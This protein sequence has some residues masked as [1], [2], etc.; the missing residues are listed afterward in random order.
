[1]KHTD[2][3]RLFSERNFQPLA[4]WDHVIVPYLVARPVLIGAGAITASG[5]VL[6]SRAAAVTHVFHHSADPQRPIVHLRR[7]DLEDEYLRIQITCGDG[8][9]FL[10]TTRRKLSVTSNI[11]L[12]AVDGAFRGLDL[13]L[14][15][16]IAAMHAVA[17]D[18]FA[19]VQLRDGKNIDAPSILEQILA[20]LK[21]SFPHP[22]GDYDPDS[23]A[24][25][26]AFERWRRTS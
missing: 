12:A 20:T 10:G 13:S 9:T 5:F 18:P 24:L 3:F 14:R 6:S 21:G 23:A 16:P 17:R 11:L 2:Y 15:N 7:P 8:N 19:R 25:Q 4:V 26:D 22:F 1:L